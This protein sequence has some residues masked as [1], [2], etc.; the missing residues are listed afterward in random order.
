MMSPDTSLRK[1]YSVGK[2]GG[3]IETI[4]RCKWSL[5]VFHLISNQINRPGEMVRSVDGLSTKVLNDCLRA[6]VKF[7]ILKKHSFAEI[8]PRVEYSFTD[9]G[10]KF[11]AII[12]QIQ[13]L[14]DEMDGQRL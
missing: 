7:G 14:E 5:T 9:Y 4:F 1:I 6:N 12:L 13:T 3:L 8:P 2:T 10:E 11:I